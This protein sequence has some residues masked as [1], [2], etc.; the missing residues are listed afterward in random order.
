MF[1]C[2]GALFCG[3]STY[4]T[5]EEMEADY[6]SGALHPGDLKPSLA[7]AINAMLEPVRQHFAQG[8]PKKLLA[9]VKKYRVTR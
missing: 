3:F 7:D 5:Y 1:V 8:E 9:Q 4:T 6:A 2:R